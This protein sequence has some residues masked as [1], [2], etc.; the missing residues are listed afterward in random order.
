VR[1]REF[2]P[3]SG[4]GS[5]FGSGLHA[6]RGEARDASSC[7]RD[8]RVAPAARGSDAVGS[9]ASRP[10]PSLRRRLAVASSAFAGE[11]RTAWRVL[12]DV[13]GDTKGE[14]AAAKYVQSC[15]SRAQDNT[16]L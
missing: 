2:G 4:S 15:P 6:R 8:S 1:R 5:G 10:S 3:G 14:R 13:L 7:A 11:V 16:R 12:C 9:F